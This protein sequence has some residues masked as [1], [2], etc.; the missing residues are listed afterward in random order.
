[1]SERIAEL[2]TRTRFEPAE[3]E[4]RMLERWLASGLFHPEP[5]GEASENY[6]IAI[7]PPNITG[8][9]HMGHALNSTIQDALIRYQRM[10]GRRAKWILGTDHAGIA[11]QAQVEKALLAEGKSRHEIGRE[12]FLARVWEWREHYGHAIVEQLKRLGASCDYSDERFT[13]DEGYARAVAEVFVALYEK[14][15]I[16]RDRYIVNWDPGS[17]SAISDLEV[18][19]RRETD[20]LYSIR[21]DLEGGGSVTIAT[22]RPETMLGDTAVAV[23]PDDERYRDLPGR[24]AILP[25]VG[26]HLPI[27]AD[28]YVK[29]D[30]GTGQL[31]VTPAHDP[32][33]FEIG[34]RH[35]LDQVSVIGEDGR[36]T[37]EAGERFAGLPVMEAREA[38][39]A[40]LESEGRILAREPYEHEVPYSHRSGERIEPLISLQWFMS[41]DE[42]ARPAV[43]AVLDG[44]VRIV[45][46]NHRRVYLDWMAAIRP[47]CISRQLWWGH[48]LPVYY[49]ETCAHVNVSVRPPERCSECGGRVR[50][51]E[52]VLDTWFSSALWPFATLGWPEQTSELRAFHPTDVLSTARDILF[53][54]VARMIMMGLE[55]TGE[56]PF[57]DVYIHS[58]IQAPDGRRMSKSLGTGIDPLREIDRHGAD[59]VRFGLLAMSSTQDVRYS[60]E[61]VQQGQALANKLF[62][63]AR[64]ALLRIQASLGAEVATQL[65][66]EPMPR[67]IE[68]R[69]ILSRLAQIEADTAAR[70]EDYD[71]SHAALGLYDF[72]YGELCDWYLELVKHRLPDF[73]AAA[74]QSADMEEREALAATLL[75][76]LRQ[77]VALAHPVVPFVTEELWSYLDGSGR[78][79]AGSPYPCADESLTDLEAE[80][81][82]E[83]AIEAVVAVRGWRDSVGARAGASIPARLSAQGYEAVAL[84]VARMTRLRFDDDS[85][86]GILAGAGSS[87]GERD[88]TGAA[89]EGDG[90]GVGE[91]DRTGVGGATRAHARPVAS[92][93]V[94]GGTI[95]ILG[96][97]GIDLQAAKRRRA[98][99]R[100]KLQ[101]ELQRVRGKLENEGFLVN[102]PAPV[103]EAE[104]ERLQR[105]SAELEAL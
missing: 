17:R 47:W 102:A 105:L 99:A 63:A 48:R 80:V 88:E 22:V 69:W 94:P 2:E 4:P 36:L 7:P 9:L 66:P 68:D 20:T 23:H 31:K 82:L 81:A 35:D 26:R 55:L 46:E 77:T 67:A 12:A 95:E 37:A 64:F 79:L 61:K 11:T 54:W 1:M 76:V 30:F 72:V 70:I 86:S 83:R 52:D 104:R 84:L 29:M 78:L 21:Y 103:V 5:E 97:E 33:D 34:R 51:E 87:A 38:V 44:R 98:A 50:Q 3:V 65:A 32:N 96:A 19:E 53:L 45:P 57:A 42:L 43:E 89:G 58:V 59:A 100:E 39:V 92:I 75:Y 27:V 13:L 49:C 71:F 74:G 28:D 56:V 101:A 18:E 41:M 73:D 15:W 10:N 25:L 93:P 62:N 24:K 8:S 60:A 85:S 90:M 91:G 16:Y 40:A 14:G 6:S